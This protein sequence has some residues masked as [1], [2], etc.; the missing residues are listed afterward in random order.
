[1]ARFAARGIRAAILVSVI[2]AATLFIFGKVRFGALA[3]ALT[4]ASLAAARAQGVLPAV[5]RIRRARTDVV[6]AAVIA[7]ALATLAL[8]LPLGR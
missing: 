2:L 5:L 1:M 8:A 4:F 7:V 6:I 3:L